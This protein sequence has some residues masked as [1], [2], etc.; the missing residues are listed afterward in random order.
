[1]TISPTARL[2]AL[3]KTQLDNMNVASQRAGGL[4]SRLDAMQYNGVPVITGATTV[5]MKVISYSIN[6]ALASA[7]GIHATILE[8]SGVQTITTGITNPDFARQVTVTG[9]QASVTGNVIITGTDVLGAPLTETLASS[10]TSTVIS[11][12]A[13]ATVTS[14]QVPALASAGDG[15]SVGTGAKIG[16]PVA[17]PQTTLVLVKNFNGATDSGTVTAG[18]TAKLSVYGA[19]GTF[20][21][22]KILQ[23]IFIA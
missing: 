9:N 15:V 21:G 7:T 3:Q 22:T 16:F 1:M 17:I 20:D 19:A 2:T 14:I 6:P 10:G 5:G 11:N 23:L 8:T 4:G 12:N 18:A 13:F